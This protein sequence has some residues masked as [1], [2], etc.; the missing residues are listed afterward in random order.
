MANSGNDSVNKPVVGND[1]V[2][3]A[4]VYEDEIHLIEYFLV[5]WKYKWFILA[6]S[7][8]PPLAS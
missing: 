6:C 4:S 8:L 2:E 5:L 3:G 7:V 1:I